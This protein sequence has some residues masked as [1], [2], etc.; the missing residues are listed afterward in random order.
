MKYFTLRQ[1]K[2]KENVKLTYFEVFPCPTLKVLFVSV[3]KY[4]HIHFDVPLMSM[5]F[6]SS[7][8][9]CLYLK[10]ASWKKQGVIDDE[11][12]RMV[13]RNDC[14]CLFCGNYLTTIDPSLCSSSSPLF[15]RFYCCCCCIG[16]ANRLI[17]L[18]LP[19]STLRTTGGVRAPLAKL[20]VTRRNS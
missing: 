18:M 2:K 7:N 5:S 1:Q 13:F 15:A 14:C 11:C 6:L 19:W 12:V 3:R 8:P 4:L 10:S 17:K 16:G 9:K 20:S